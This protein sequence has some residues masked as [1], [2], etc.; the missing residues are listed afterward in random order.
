MNYAYMWTATLP[1]SQLPRAPARSL[2]T[3]LECTNPVR[4]KRPLG[5]PRKD[6]IRRC[7]CAVST[8]CVLLKPCIYIIWA[9]KYI[10]GQKM[11]FCELIELRTNK[12][13]MVLYIIV[14][15]R[16]IIISKRSSNC[17]LYNLSIIYFGY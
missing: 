5:R 8:V 14:M 15:Y 9:K 10:S 16:L 6:E 11:Q 13:N 7:K 2:S 12:A 17:L 3:A 4:K 1:A